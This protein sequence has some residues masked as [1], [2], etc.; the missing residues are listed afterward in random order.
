MGHFV[1]SQKRDRRDSRKDETLVD[2]LRWGLTTHQPLWVIL[3]L[4][5]E[6]GRKEIKEV[7]E[8]MKVRDREEKGTGVKVKK[9]KKNKTFPLPYLLQ[10]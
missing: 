6:K 5:P 9:Q 2:L 3:C 7:E 10:G 8:E 1:S 4:L